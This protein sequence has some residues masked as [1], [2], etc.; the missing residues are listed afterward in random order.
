MGLTYNMIHLVDIIEFRNENIKDNQ[1]PDLIY[2]STTN[3]RPEKAGIDLTNNESVGKSGKRFYSGDVLI[4]NIRPYFKKIWYANREGICSA[5]ILIFRPKEESLYNKRFLYYLL[6][7]DIFFNYMTST[8]KGTKMPRGDKDAIKRYTVPEYEYSQQLSI[9]KLL[10]SFDKNIEKNNAIIA[11]IEEQA[12]VIFKSWFVDFEPFKDEELVDSKLGKIPYKWSIKEANNWFLINIGKTPPRKQTEWFT[13]SSR[14]I[15]WLSISDMKNSHTFVGESSEYLTEEA[16]DR[17]NIRLAPANS[18]LVSFKLTIGRVA[19]TREKLTTNEA[20][21]H[22]HIN[23]EF[24]LYY[25]YLYLKLFNYKELGNTSSIGNAVNSKIIKA[26]SILKPTEEVL[27]K[28]HTIIK[29]FFDMIYEKIEENKKLKEL[30]DIL[31]PKL[32]SGEIRVEEA[33]EIE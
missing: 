1:D 16:I 18:V 9:L 28:F 2:I 30:R 7:N 11:N 21:A 3:M 31:L 13:T 5:D 32:M 15:K 27:V 4:S 26:M 14:D 24:E 33:V 8:S 12:K 22:F 6:S 29:P 19:I 25:L 17:F 10:S 23:K 20:I